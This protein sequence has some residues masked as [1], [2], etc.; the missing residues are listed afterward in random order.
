MSEE[1]T[2][3]RVIKKSQTPAQSA[4]V[5]SAQQS[6]ASS[7]PEKKVVVIKKK[8]VTVKAKVKDEKKEETAAAAPVQQNVQAKPEVRNTLVQPSVS[9]QI[10]QASSSGNS[11][12]SPTVPA[13]NRNLVGGERVN[14]ILHNGPVVIKASNLPPVPGQVVSTPQP[15][16]RPRVAGIV[17]G[18]RFTFRRQQCRRTVFQPSGRIFQSSGTSFSRSCRRRGEP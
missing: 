8:I 11:R 6:A 5:Q 15:S 4:P 12:L 17:G 16:G 2:K 3:I 13:A 14:S 10:K 9:P 1:K 7:N 18:R